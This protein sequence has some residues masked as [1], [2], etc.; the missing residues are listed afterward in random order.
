MKKVVL[1]NCLAV[2]VFFNVCVM[3]ISCA[4]EK[5]EEI[6]EAG[7]SPSKPSLEAP[8]KSTKFPNSKAG[9]STTL[10][11]FVSPQDQIRTKLALAGY[12]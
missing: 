10:R 8:A 4:K 3:L 12:E 2:F 5:A 1:L 9:V 11:N 7:A 6:K